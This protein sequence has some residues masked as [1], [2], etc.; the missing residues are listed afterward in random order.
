MIETETCELGNHEQC[1]STL[2]VTISSAYS[3]WHWPYQF[4]PQLQRMLHCGNKPVGLFA[5]PWGRDWLS[6]AHTTSAALPCRY[7]SGPGG[8][9]EGP[10]AQRQ[11]SQDLPPRGPTSNGPAGGGPSGAALHHLWMRLSRLAPATHAARRCHAEPGPLL[12][13]HYAIYAAFAHRQCP[14]W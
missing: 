11:Q 7:G 12:V 6:G 13:L 10:P 14:P 4:C 9:S 5:R 1:R 3:L 2:R 8:F